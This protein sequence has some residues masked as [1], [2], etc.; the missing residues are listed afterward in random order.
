MMNIMDPIKLVD[1]Q[2]QFDMHGPGIYMI[3][4]PDSKKAYI[5]Q[6]NDMKRRWRNHKAALNN[7]KH[8]NRYLQR[9]FDKYNGN[10]CFYIL[11]NTDNRNQREEYWASL[12]PKILLLNETKVGG[13]HSDFSK[14]KIKPDQY[15]ELVSL[16]RGGM[17]VDN[18]ASYYS[19]S[20]RMLY[21]YLNR[22]GES[23]MNRKSKQ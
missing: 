9:T 21:K 10:L 1:S 6:S 18:L 14:A 16:Y 17:Q 20:R 15:Q 11:E 23:R 13:V 2:I 3:Y 4:C 19:I 8:Y 22:L 12:V 5:G 7:G